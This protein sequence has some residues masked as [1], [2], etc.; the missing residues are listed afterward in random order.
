MRVA[1]RRLPP[2]N[3]HNQKSLKLG[4][5]ESAAGTEDEAV[6]VA[7]GVA[8]EDEETVLARE[9]TTVKCSLTSVPLCPTMIMKKCNLTSG[10]PQ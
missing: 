2:P 10:N 3:Q 7:E 8:V 6:G 4:E 9:K 1:K 5:G